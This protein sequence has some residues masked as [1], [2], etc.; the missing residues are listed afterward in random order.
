CGADALAAPTSPPEV[1]YAGSAPPVRASP[2]I[3]SEPEPSPVEVLPLSEPEPGPPAAPAPAQEA[4]LPPC[5]DC[6]KPLSNVL[7]CSVCPGLFC[8]GACLREHVRSTG[9]VQQPEPSQPQPE[10][11]PPLPNTGLMAL[12][13]VG[14]C[15]LLFG[16]AGVGIYLA[17]QGDGT[18]N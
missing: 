1:V 11:A 4:P 5:L 14:G 17:A 3:E 2:L 9:H 13:V 12:L 15:L 10:P 18:P 16:L 7:R 8:C 6:G